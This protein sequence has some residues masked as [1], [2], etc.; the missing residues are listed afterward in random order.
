[1]V[2]PI[3]A[4]PIGSVWGCCLTSTVTSRLSRPG[5]TLERVSTCSMWEVKCMQSV[6]R[7]QV[8]SCRAPTP[9][10]A[11]TGTQQ[12]FARYRQVSVTPTDRSRDLFTL[13]IHCSPYSFSLLSRVISWSK[14][15]EN[16]MVVMCVLI[17]WTSLFCKLARNWIL[18][19]NVFTATMLIT[20]YPTLH[21]D[22]QSTLT[23]SGLDWTM[24]WI[25]FWTQIWTDADHF[26]QDKKEV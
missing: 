12:Q 3:Q 16:V 21:M 20:S 13:H 10:C 23:N 9:T 6:S 14:L 11:M 4:Q 25:Q 22:W 8:S 2:S 18:I 1:M 7:K 19:N 5:G 26:Q 15:S 17:M 24:D